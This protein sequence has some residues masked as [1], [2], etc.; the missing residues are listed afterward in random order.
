MCTVLLTESCFSCRFD[1]LSYAQLVCRIAIY[2]HLLMR[3]IHV[4]EQIVL[5]SAEDRSMS[6]L[7]MCA[8]DYMV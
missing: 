4:A 8:Y 7:N 1:A 2:A 3:S 6:G 5:E